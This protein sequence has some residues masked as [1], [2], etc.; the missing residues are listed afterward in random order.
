MP[1]EAELPNSL[2]LISAEYENTNIQ[3]GYAEILYKDI[4]TILIIFIIF[5]IIITGITFIS[6]MNR[7]QGGGGY[8]SRP[9]VGEEFG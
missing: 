2:F 1:G 7:P 9:L 5:S 4:N 3:G 8:P 6:Y